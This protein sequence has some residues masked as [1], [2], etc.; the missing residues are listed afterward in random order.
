M[1]G[2]RQSIVFSKED[3]Y[4]QGK[5]ANCAWIAPPPGT[6]FTSTHNRN[7]QRIQTTGS[8][9]WDTQAYGQ[10]AGSWSWT[11]TMD[12]EYLEPFFFV[13]EKITAGN[14]STQPMFKN[15]PD[16]PG[17][18]SPPATFKFEKI[19]NDRIPSFT[20]LRK[21]N[22]QMVGGDRNEITQLTGCVVKS[23]QIQRSAATSKIDVSLSG[24]YSNE[25]LMAA[26][27][28]SGIWPTDYQ[29]YKNATGGLIEYSCL[30]AGTLVDGEYMANTE[31]ISIGM[32]NSAAA[33]YSV[34]SPFASNYYEGLTSIT[35]STTCY[36]TDPLQ[37]KTRLYSGGFTN[38]PP[39]GNGDS[40][41][42]PMSKGMKPVP[43]MS[44][45]CYSNQI[46]RDDPTYE[47]DPGAGQ[48]GLPYNDV[49]ETDTSTEPPTV[50]VNHEGSVAQAFADSDRFVGFQLDQVVVK[51]LP[52]QKGD[53][54]KLQDSLSGSEVRKLTMYVKSANA[55]A[56]ADWFASTNKHS[57]DVKDPDENGT[58]D[59]EY[60]SLLPLQ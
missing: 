58:E 26:D 37:Y 27:K 46:N 52:W 19:N 8:K 45:A 25:R 38:R 11:F 9:F 43:I 7:V 39:D 47:P 35:F 44:I 13:F 55:P 28:K 22:N 59:F 56:Y 14:I 33:V 40:P 6:F 21:I 15:A 32:D 2:I 31:S 23:F 49:T 54:S 4:G 42:A 10:L 30:Y 1:T 12:Y 3:T 16:G 29:E 60:D 51:S 5:G 36:S 48:D 20:V 34:C 17:S 53:G 18:T 24:F 57:V 41:Y 50:T